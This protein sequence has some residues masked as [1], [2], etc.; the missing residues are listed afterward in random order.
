MGGLGMR[1]GFMTCPERRQI[2]FRALLKIC[3]DLTG[4]WAAVDKRSQPGLGV[5]AK[6]SFFQK[7]GP[8]AANWHAA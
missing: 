3:A 2:W 5:A 1:S 8:R 6:P 7:L 4:L